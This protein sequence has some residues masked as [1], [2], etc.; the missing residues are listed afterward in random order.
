MARERTVHQ[1]R[2]NLLKV[3]YQPQDL[4]AKVRQDF[5]VRSVTWLACA[6]C[7]KY[8]HHCLAEPFEPIGDIYIS[9]EII[10]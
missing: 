10:G 4:R 3:G 9:S 6:H 5:G 7:P 2:Y 1:E 8:V